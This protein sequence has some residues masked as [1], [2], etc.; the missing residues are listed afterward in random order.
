MTLFNIECVL[1]DATSTTPVV[2]YYTYGVN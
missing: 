1:L 2:S